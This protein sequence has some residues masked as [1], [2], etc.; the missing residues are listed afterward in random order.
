MFSVK[1]LQSISVFRQKI[2]NMTFSIIKIPKKGK[3]IV[4]IIFKF[5]ISIPI[6]IL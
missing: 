1:N 6:L 4:Y 2:L 5:F 3:L